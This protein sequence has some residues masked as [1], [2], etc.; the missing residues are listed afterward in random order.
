M[1]LVRR[2]RTLGAAA[3]GGAVVAAALAP[4]ANAATLSAPASASLGGHISVKASGLIAGRYQ[5][6][7]AYTRPQ[8]SGGQTVNCSAS[9]GAAKTVGSSA[10]FSG[11]IPLKLTCRTDSGGTAETEPV[12]A[13]RYDVAIYSPVG[14][15]TYNGR[16]SFVQRSITITG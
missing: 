1:N 2:T 9:I 16:R 12:A 5:L 8:S 3:L 4:A 14:A 13:G 11:S 15:N 10:T 7:L 6:F